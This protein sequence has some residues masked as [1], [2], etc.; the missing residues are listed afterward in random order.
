MI[1]NTGRIPA[2]LILLTLDLK[3]VFYHSLRLVS[4]AQHKKWTLGEKAS[5]FRAKIAKSVYQHL[6]S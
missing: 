1:T 5:W 2:K 3:H 6:S 4:L